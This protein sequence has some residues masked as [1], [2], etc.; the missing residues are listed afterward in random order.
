[1]TP[2]EQEQKIQ[3]LKD[4]LPDEWKEAFDELIPLSSA[5]YK[6]CKKWGVPL[7]QGMQIG[8]VGIMASRYNPS[9]DDPSKQTIHPLMGLASLL[10]QGEDPMAVAL[11]VIS[12]VVQAKAQQED[13]EAA[14]PQ[15]AGGGDRP[16]AIPVLGPSGVN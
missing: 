16:F 3:D 7:L 8:D 5:M 6:A 10:L 12:I 9:A 2:E 14:S 4:G 1:M 15:V 13:A 11:R